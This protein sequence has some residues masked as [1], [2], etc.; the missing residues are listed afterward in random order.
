MK[1][2]NENQKVTL[3][4]GQLR[5]LIRESNEESDFEVKKGVL[6]KY[7]GNGGDVVI[8]DSVDCI[9]EEAFAGCTSLT[10]ITIPDG[11]TSIGAGAFSDCSSLTSL[12]IPAG[13]IFVGMSA[14]YG[15]SSLTSVTVPGSLMHISWNMFANCTSLTSVKIENGVKKIGL[16]AFSNCG[17][18]TFVTIP[19]SVTSIEK[20]A[21]E[22]CEKL[23][24]VELPTHLSETIHKNPNFSFGSTPFAT[25][26]RQ[27][28]IDPKY[29]TRKS[30]AKKCPNY[31]DIKKALWNDGDVSKETL[32]K[33]CLEYMGIDD[34]W[35]MA[36]IE[37]GYTEEK[38][39]Y[40]DRM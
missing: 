16:G 18:L 11:V 26:L 35:S 39:D 4:M 14:F 2:I 30:S 31:V 29:F 17:A 38:S 32:A 27:Y 3:T 20:G 33:K 10:S 19:D 21:F 36:K 13:I 25:K 6:L 1:R 37:F 24:A 12:V 40:L 34:V 8:P 22:N 28:R 9:G 7:Y 15:C 23:E 5:K